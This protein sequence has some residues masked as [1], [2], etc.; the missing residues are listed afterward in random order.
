V[1][2]PIADSGH[3][4]AL[5]IDGKNRSI[6]YW[7]PF[8]TSV[9]KTRLV[10]PLSQC[11]PEFVVRDKLL[12][13][14]ND[15]VT[16]GLWVIYAYARYYLYLTGELPTFTLTEKSEGSYIPRNLSATPHA[17]PA[18]NRSFINEFRKNVATEL[19]EHIDNA[20]IN[21]T[22]LTETDIPSSSS[23]SASPSGAATAASSS[24]S[25]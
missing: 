11:Y 3:W 10:K 16:C 19:N 14:Q 7:E 6:T 24:S 20:T 21:L 8:G 18:I 22:L 4:K 1:F 13:L 25:L 2:I 9:R 15:V 5:I 17:D 12:C 23:S